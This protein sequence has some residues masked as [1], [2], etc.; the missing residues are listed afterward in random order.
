MRA[1]LDL[2]DL[3]LE[4]LTPRATEEA[5]EPLDWLLVRGI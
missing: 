2:G 4:V 5:G 1:G 3:A